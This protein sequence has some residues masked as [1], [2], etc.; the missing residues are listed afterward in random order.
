[1][2]PLGASLRVS[3]RD[4]WGDCNGVSGVRP[5]F[6]VDSAHLHILRSSCTMARLADSRAVFVVEVRACITAVSFHRT[7]TYPTLSLHDSTVT[8]SCAVFAVK[9]RPCL[10]LYYGTA[11]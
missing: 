5:H 2:L 9:V 8:D 4:L 11:C 7:R 1:M 6:V 3:V 10:L